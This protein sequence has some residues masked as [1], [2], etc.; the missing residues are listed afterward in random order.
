MLILVSSFFSLSQIIR[1]ENLSSDITT[2]G[3]S[4]SG[5]LDL[6]ENGYPDLLVGAYESDAV[7]LLRSRPIV[8]IRTNVHPEK[9][10]V[11]IDPNGQG[12]DRDREYKH[13]W[14]VLLPPHLLRNI[15]Q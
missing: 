1:A 10:L 12:C 3:Y 6:D 8:G 9:N 11:N 4:L 2:F 14:Y 5:G 7:V 13:T 15:Y